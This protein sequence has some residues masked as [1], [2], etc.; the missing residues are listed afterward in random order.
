MIARGEGPN[1]WDGTFSSNRCT[2]TRAGN[3]I[4]ATFLPTAWP[5][6]GC[7]LAAAQDWSGAALTFHVANPGSEPV[8]FN[9]R[10]D[11]DASADGAHHCDT[12][13][14]I[15]E[16][17]PEETYVCAL[18]EDPMDYGMRRLPPS[19]IGTDLSGSA[20]VQADHI[21]RWQIFLA[22][23]V[24]PTTLMVSD[25]KVQPAGYLDLK[26][27]L[28]GFG[29]FTRATWPGKVTSADDLRASSG[30]D[31][32][33]T[34]RPG[35]DPY[36]GWLSGPPQSATGRFRTQRVDG[37]WWLVTPEGHLFFSI[38]C[39]C[40]AY[41]DPT[42]VTGREAMFAGLPSPGDP[43]AVFYGKEWWALRGPMAGKQTETY[44]FFGAN[45]QLKY[46]D[47]WKAISTAVAENRLH[48]W[49]F[50]TVGNW[51]NTDVKVLRKI[52]YVATVSVGGAHSIATGSDYWGP[53]PDVFDPTYPAMVAKT[54]QDQNFAIGDPWCIG[55][56]IDNE[57]SW[58]GSAGTNEEAGRFGL[59]YG[60][61]VLGAEAPAKQE[62]LRELKAKYLTID[63]LNTQWGTSFPSWEVLAGPVPTLGGQPKN[64]RDDLIVFCR[65]YANRYFST[66]RRAV[67]EADPHALY[68]GCR[69]AGGTTPD[70]AQA[71][72]QYCDVISY[73]IYRRSIDEVNWA[74]VAKLGKPLIIGEFHFGATD[75]GMFHPGL[76]PTAN[77]AA[78]AQAY[79]AYVQSVVTNPLFVGCHWFQYLDEPTLGRVLDGENYN[80]G[81]VS[82]AD[83]PYPELVNAASAINQQVYTL[84][85][86][87]SD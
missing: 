62:L 5:N 56:F 71:A 52:P 64:R 35:F 60:A 19:P 36:G 11:D 34:P 2:V 33:W 23:P 17:G 75:R 84:R 55:W 13:S 53:M 48:A 49:G 66:M 57:L 42:I 20:S 51:S 14:G 54:L 27:I 28:D 85:E 8:H 24:T 30:E 77:Q 10:I 29:Q 63:A 74:D 78:R 16:P 12:F 70:A 44:D 21:V 6:F 4:K 39:D 22:S 72:A 61:L 82:V 87:S 31:R 15:A 47:D 67:R 41:S 65:A 58:A 1:P 9:V 69:F 46:G 43:L 3:A 7:A 76:G 73:N 38:G 68:L 80:I 40:V 26:G 50:N 86:A 83:V 25:I 79:V 81:L 59:A 18:R 37:K 45:R 32:V